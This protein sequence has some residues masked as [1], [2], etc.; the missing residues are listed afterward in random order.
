MWNGQD[1]NRDG[2]EIMTDLEKLKKTIENLVTPEAMIATMLTALESL[3]PERDALKAELANAR[4]SEPQMPGAWICPKCKCCVQKS[5]MHTGDG[6]ITADTSPINQVCPNNCGLMRPLT[7]REVNEDLSERA[8]AELKRANEL[9]AEV[10]RLTRELGEERQG[11]PAEQPL[12]DVPLD[13]QI[14]LLNRRLSEAVREN[15]ILRGLLPKL[16]APCVYCGEIELGKCTRGFPGCAKADDLM[17]GEDEAFRRLVE[18]RNQL[19]KEIIGLA[20]VLQAHHK[21]ASEAGNVYFEQDGKP[22]DVVTDLGEAYQ[23][24]DLCDKTMAALARA[25]EVGQ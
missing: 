7:W 23:E 4:R 13:R 17:C 21:H 12:I 1:S 16:G 22:I 25:K 10:A 19:K 6:A 3:I 11:R 8:M 20:D 15:T 5:I 14:V 24:S 18:E 2:A 9:E